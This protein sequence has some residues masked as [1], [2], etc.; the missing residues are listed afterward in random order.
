MEGVN[1][2]YRGCRCK[3]RMSGLCKVEMSGSM[4]GG[5]RHGA[6]ANRVECKRAGTTEGV[7]RTRAMRAA[8]D[9]A[10]WVRSNDGEDAT[11]LVRAWR[12]EESATRDFMPMS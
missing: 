12:E 8:K 2:P 3:M 11:D 5:R 6:G 9:F 4:R 10:D 7:A 1:D